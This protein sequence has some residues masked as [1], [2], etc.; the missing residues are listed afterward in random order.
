M[1]AALADL[2][3]THFDTAGEKGMTPWSANAAAGALSE[4]APFR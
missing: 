2:S 4:S 3:T 1:P